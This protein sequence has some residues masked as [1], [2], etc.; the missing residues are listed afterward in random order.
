M[1]RVSLMGK[2]TLSKILERFSHSLTLRWRLTLLTAGLLF[3][4]GLSLTVFTNV[5]TSI[6]IPQVLTVELVPTQLPPSGHTPPDT[7]SR[8]S[9][10][11]NDLAPTSIEQLQ[12]IAIQEFRLI[13]IL[14]VG[15]FSLIGAIC[16]YW[17]SRQALYPLHHLNRLVSEIRPNSLDQRLSLN[18]PDG[19]IKQL[20]D[21]FDNMLERLE[22]AFEQ[23]G[24]FV[25]D[26]AHELRTP[27][28]NMRTNL[29][30]IQQDPNASGSDFRDLTQTFERSLDRLERLVEDLLLLAKGER[31]IQR[32]PVSLEVL[33]KKVIQ[34]TE[35]L[36]QK[37]QINVKLE[38]AGTH[39]L[40]VDT[41]L[42]SIAFRNLIVNGIQYN[43]P[44]GKVTAKVKVEENTAVIKVKDTGIGI[45][46]RD[47]PNIFE[48]FHRVDR[49]RARHLGGAGLGLSIAAHIVE[50][51][52]GS[53]EAES[54]SGKGSCF[55]I[56]LPL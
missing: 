15:L 56:R 8:G 32:E 25:A 54:E 10:T 47:L 3:F 42:L 28:A 45:P 24:R 31:A 23:Q 6:R 18:W 11:N 43:H 16:A 38:S 39:I 37:H 41:P 40:A 7:S 22:L 13:T 12:N 9:P 35:A 20:S 5:I 14:G 21:A 4:L 17:I 1:K 19:E 53:I 44:G 30:V 34:D 50:L 36:S 46:K 2:R 55:I 29:E 48:R 49:S 26:A 52:G 51:H 33:L 27:L